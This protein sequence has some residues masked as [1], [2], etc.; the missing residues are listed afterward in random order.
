MQML[1]H[2]FTVLAF[3]VVPTGLFGMEKNKQLSEFMTVD[4][5]M[6]LP[7]IHT[8]IEHSATRCSALET[9]HALSLVNRSMRLSLHE[10]K[11]EIHNIISRKLGYEDLVYPDQKNAELYR[12]RKIII[13]DA[14]AEEHAIKEQYGY[15]A[16]Y[17]STGIF[18]MNQVLA[19]LEQNKQTASNDEINNILNAYSW[20]LTRYNYQLSATLL[21]LFKHAA[22]HLTDNSHLK[23]TYSDII[24]PTLTGFSPRII[25]LSLKTGKDLFGEHF[26]EIPGLRSHK[27]LIDSVVDLCKKHDQVIAQLIQ[28]AVIKDIKNR[29]GLDKK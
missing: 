27:T 8:L 10:Q 5:P 23:K 24:K 21:G 9:M 3:C 17:S 19:Y 15:T 4:S 6:P 18:K 29:Y 16:L 12:I 28:N 20:S 22:Q 25:Q 26:F 1:R 7:V 13:A 11:D 2:F 14:I